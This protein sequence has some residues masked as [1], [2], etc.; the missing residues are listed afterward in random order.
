LQPFEIFT[1]CVA[2]LFVGVLQF[3]KI[4]DKSY[5]WQALLQKNRKMLATWKFFEFFFGSTLEIFW[6][7]VACP[8]DDADEFLLPLYQNLFLKAFI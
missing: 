2:C 8:E 7:Y 5:F 6:V 3:A 1:V 4:S